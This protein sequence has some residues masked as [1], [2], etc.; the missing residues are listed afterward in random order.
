MAK[1]QMIDSVNPHTIAEVYAEVDIN[2]FRKDQ[3][4]YEITEEEVIKPQKVAKQ[5]KVDKDTLA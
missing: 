2:S 3:N 1:F 5:P 4:W